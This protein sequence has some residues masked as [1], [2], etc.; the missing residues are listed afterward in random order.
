MHLD[1]HLIMLKC[2]LVGLDWVLP[3]IYLFL[4]VTCLCIF[5]AYVFSLFFLRYSGGDVFSLF[6]PLFLLKFLGWALCI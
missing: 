3:M 6:L 2:M 1:V 4:H 5:H